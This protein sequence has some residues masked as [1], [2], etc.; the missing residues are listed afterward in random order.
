M[1]NIYPKKKFKNIG[2]TKIHAG[3][4]VAFIG[5]RKKQKVVAYREI[6]A[7]IAAENDNN[8]PGNKID[9]YVP[10][11]EEKKFVIHYYIPHMV[12]MMGGCMSTK[13]ACGANVKSI[14]MYKQ[15]VTCNNCKR[16]KQFNAR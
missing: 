7:G 8:S 2:K 1:Q 13:S 12:E 3:E 6:A 5:D 15:L 9:V 10:P 4:L 16:T 11:P 14:T